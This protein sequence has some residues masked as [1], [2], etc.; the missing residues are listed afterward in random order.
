M[1]LVAAVF[2]GSLSAV[3]GR[4]SDR[5][6]RLGPIRIGLAGAALLA[7]LL[8]LPADP[9]VLAAAVVAAA[10]ALAAFWAP[11][12]ALLS[13]VGETMGLD[14]GY[15]FALTN[16]A[17][18]GGQVGGGAAGGWVAERAGDA[19]PYGVLALLC[20][21]TLAGVTVR[22]RPLPRGPQRSQARS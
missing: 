8:P 12:F 16:L 4:I 22:R 1:F 19:V 3:M 2:E 14:Q 15:A 10:A 11:A 20:S 21:L 18:A 7:V 13:D 17:W 6:G 9:L 5:R